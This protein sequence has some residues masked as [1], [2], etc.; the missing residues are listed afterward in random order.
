[1]TFTRSL[2]N[3]NE[4]EI[5]QGEAANPTMVK[6]NQATDIKVSRAVEISKNCR[7]ND[8]GPRVTFHLNDNYPDEEEFIVDGKN[9][10]VTAN[11]YIPHGKLEVDGDENG[12]TI[13]TGLFV[14][15]EL[16]SGEN[17]I[18]NKNICVNPLAPVS[19]MPGSEITNS[20][21]LNPANKANLLITSTLAVPGGLNAIIYPNPT[22]GE[23]NLKVLTN[24]TEPI[25]VRILD[26]MGTNIQSFA[27]VAKSGIMKLSQSNRGG[28]YFVEVTQGKQRKV[29]RLV[30]TN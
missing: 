16:E 3:L 22:S 12:S 27:N 14:I 5:K 29:L 18:W 28:T 4:L 1:M 17:V 20:Q 15:E 19:V 30:R 8:G 10:V 9:T 6:F 7:I 21:V 11:I 13:M 25:S 2:I 23:F 24:A 26:A